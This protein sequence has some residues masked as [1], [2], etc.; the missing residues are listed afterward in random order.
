MGLTEILLSAFLAVGDPVLYVLLGLSVV[1]V[2]CSLER[3]VVIVK[4][5]R[6]DRLTEHR[7]E[8][9]LALAQKDNGELLE[10]LRN[11]KSALAGIF[12][13]ALATPTWEAQRFDEE[14]GALS[15]RYRKSLERGLVVLASI[16]SN[17]PFIGLFGTVL[18]IIKA[19]NDLG[20]ASTMNA[21]IVMKGISE[22]LVA[23]GM[24]LLVAIPTVIA[25]NFFQNAAELQLDRVE[26]LKKLLLARLPVA[27]V[28]APVPAK[29]EHRGS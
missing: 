22:A 15:I 18:G 11:D 20:M 7:I 1:T 2:A 17:A 25:Y 9:S 26:S 29:D 19:F 27:S 21:N 23:T 13:A 6:S 3:L 8:H 10:T 28:S 24:G 16:G 12:A 5:R 14:V 4:H